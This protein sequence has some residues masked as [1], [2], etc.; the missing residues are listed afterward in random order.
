MLALV[1]TSSWKNSQLPIRCDYLQARYQPIGFV[2]TRLGNESDQQ[3]VGREYSRYLAE[4]PPRTDEKT[5]RRQTATTHHGRNGAAPGGGLDRALVDGA[6]GGCVW[7]FGVF[8][9][10]L[11]WA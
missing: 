1:L 4:R 9:S 11:G 5:K 2:R 8:G 10:G 6:G 7:L 3:D